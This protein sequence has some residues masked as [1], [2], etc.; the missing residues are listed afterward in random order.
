MTADQ[1][2]SVVFQNLLV[3]NIPIAVELKVT[4]FARIAK[5]HAQLTGVSVSDPTRITLL[6]ALLGLYR[7][8]SNR[9]DQSLCFSHSRRSNLRP[10]ANSQHR[11]NRGHA[12][13]PCPRRLAN[14]GPAARLAT[15]YWLDVW[16]GES[17]PRG[18]GIYVWL[19][20]DF[21]IELIFTPPFEPNRNSLVEY[22][23]LVSTEFLAPQPVAVVH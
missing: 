5:S 14:S 2:L 23:G 16:R 21:G 9:R 13:P 18:S 6:V 8:L 10:A 15:R 4:G 11:Y 3:P 17:L 12:L 20:L 7:V 22:Q 19:C 1:I